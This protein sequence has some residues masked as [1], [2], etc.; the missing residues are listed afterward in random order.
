M[1]LQTPYGVIIGTVHDYNLVNPDTGQWPHYHV[2]VSANGQIMDSAINLKSL[3][4][5]QIEFRSRPFDVADPRFANILALSDGLHVLAQYSTS[6]ALDYVREGALAGADNWILQNGDNLIAEMNLL[7]TGVQRIYIFGA[8]YSSGVG[9]HDVHMNQGDPDGSTFQPL[10]AIWQDGGLL[11]QYAAPQPSLKILQIKFETQS[12]F[13][14]A[15]GHP[16]KLPLPPRVYYYMPLWHWPPDNPLLD[17]ER[18]ILVED[19]LFKLASW[20]GAIAEVPEDIR[21][22]MSKS[23]C[24]Q[25]AQRLPNA[26]PAHIAQISDYLV[27]LGQVA[28]VFRG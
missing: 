13:T 11:F 17:G 28:R 3:T 26:S 10:D 16:V 19:G 5:V 15:D 6:G 14:D 18:Q 12:L 24:K 25:V 7:L 4:D 22:V 27:K 8:T 20:A 9:V 21:E 23:L 2:H 1:A